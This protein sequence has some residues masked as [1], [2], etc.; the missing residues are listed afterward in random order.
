MSKDASL[1]SFLKFE[2]GVTSPGG[3]NGLHYMTEQVG[4]Q[5]DKTRLSRKNDFK[6]PEV[7]QAGKIAN[8]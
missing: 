4:K 3:D 2:H 8:D 5:V 6:L 7:K 1:E